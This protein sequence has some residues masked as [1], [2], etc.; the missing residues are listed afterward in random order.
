MNGTTNT[1]KT[2]DPAGVGD[3][4]SVTGEHGQVNYDLHGN[5][6]EL[7]DATGDIDPMGD[8]W[9]DK[10]R[11]YAELD[12]DEAVF[13]VLADHYRTQLAGEAANHADM[14]AAMAPAGRWG[15]TR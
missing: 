11:E 15:C 9:A 14:V 4:W 5:R 7:I 2:T 6:L 10:V 3:R 13:A 8:R 1:S 12:D